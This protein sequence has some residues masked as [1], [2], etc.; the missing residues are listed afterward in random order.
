MSDS[1]SIEPDPSMI[2]R[3]SQATFIR[4]PDPAILFS[5]RA[6]R[7][8]ELARNANLAPYLEF[9]ATI[10]D[11]QSAILPDLPDVVLPASEMLERARRFEMPPIDRT[12]FK[13]DATAHETCRRH[14]EALAKI[15]KPEAADVAL[16]RIRKLDDASLDRL[17]VAVL[18]ESVPTAAL[19][20]HIYVAAALQVHFARLPAVRWQTSRVPDRWLV[21]RRGCALRRLHAL[22]NAVERGPRQMSRLRL[23]ERDWLSGNRRP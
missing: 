14:F 10:C 19:A 6:A 7:L 3:V 9:L 20:E 23:H 1:R 8:R 22:R 17:I 21:R 5:R 4:L 13:P 2:G 16:A 11:A 12:A 18:A 15:G